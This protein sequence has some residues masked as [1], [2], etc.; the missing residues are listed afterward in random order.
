MAGEQHRRGLA[1]ETTR[2]E[3]ED[4]QRPGPTESDTKKLAADRT[5]L[6]GLV[7]AS[8][9]GIEHQASGPKSK[10]FPRA[11]RTLLIL[12]SIPFK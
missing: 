5:Y 10:N 8:E 11:R 2:V 1:L 7:Q 3:P 4:S 6:N 12:E 9:D